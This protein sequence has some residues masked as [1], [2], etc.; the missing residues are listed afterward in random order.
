M[1]TDYRQSPGAARAWARALAI[2]VAF[3][4]TACAAKHPA[5]SK[6][7]ARGTRALQ[8]EIVGRLSG[9]R[10]IR[11]GVTLVNRFSVENKQEARTYL[12]GVLKGLGL[13]AKRQPYGTE[14]GEN[15]YATLASGRPGAETV[16]FGAHYDSVRA[17]PGANDDATG[18]AA[19]LAVAQELSRTR[20]R[21]RDVIFVLFDEE[22]RRLRGSQAFAQML[23]DEKRPVHSVHTIDQ[24]GWD[25]NHNRA[26]ELELPYDG[27][28]DL[29]KSAAAR[30]KMTATIYT[31]TESGSDHSAFRRLGFKAVGITEEYRHGDTTPFIH[32]A[33]DTMATVDFDYLASTTRLIV[34][35]MR[36]LT[37]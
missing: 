35:V 27:A 33:G 16:V 9:A 26:I 10:E 15:I 25:Q 34:E 18:V 4:A 17:G 2:V 20:K 28:V 36:A 3:A 29:Y 5:S 22:E 37:R 11:A 19:V 8:E 1:L 23:A 12:I 32:R 31:T 13:E 21:S 24:M 30:L 6:P 7:A 14:G